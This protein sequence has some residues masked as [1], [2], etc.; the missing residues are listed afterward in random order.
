MADSPLRRITV[1][2]CG[3]MGGSFAL[4][5]HAVPGVQAVTVVDRRPAV[6]ER[7][8]ELGVG[9]HWSTDVAAAVADADLV[10]IAT[11]VP[12]ITQV[13]LDASKWMR[14]GAVLTDL[15]SVK[16][17]L[18]V[19]LEGALPSDIPFIGGH[20][21]A[22]SEASGVDAADGTLFQGAT[23]LLTPTV[24]VQEAAFG[25]LGDLLRQMGARVLAVAPELH[26]RLVAVVSH[27]PQLLASLLMAHA[28]D[29]ADDRDAVLALTAGGFRD[30]TRVA[31][32]DPDLWTGIL[33]ENRVA[34]LEQLI[35][36]AERLESLRRLLEVDDEER[37]HR[38]L[39]DARRARRSLPRRGE[40]VD[41]IDLLVPVPDRP[42][43][44]AEVTTAL[45]EVG[46]NIEDLAMRHASDG[47]RGAMVIA[48]AGQDA[49]RRAQQ[50]LAE[51][52]YAT[53]VETR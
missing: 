13:A 46:V 10:V 52:G 4:A 31:A 11:P 38:F 12:T 39:A 43:A 33:R 48:I 42:G 7:A 20:P 9:T 21:M 3:L 27:L 32:S 51:R 36:Y 8:R 18:V 23:Y 19:E 24:G 35:R 25:V 28:A 26:D 1:I 41:L 47:G 34:V 53:H 5:A 40:A 44:L 22:G 50:V 45:G 14:S 49:L 6:V 17:N 37:L 15:G 30:V 16:S 2:G 29:T